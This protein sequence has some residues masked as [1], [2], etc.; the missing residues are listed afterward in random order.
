MKLTAATVHMYTVSSQP[1]LTW[2]V[3]SGGA[4]VSSLGSWKEG[5]RGACNVTTAWHQD[6]CMASGLLHGIRTA[7]WHQDYCMASRLL[8]GIRTT[9]WYQDYCMA[10]RLLYGIRTVAWHQDYCMASGLLRGIR[11]TAWHQDCF[12]A[13]G[14]LYGIWMLSGLLH[15]I[16]NTICMALSDCTNC[17]LLSNILL[18]TW[19]RACFAKSLAVVISITLTIV[20]Y[21]DLSHCGVDFRNEMCNALHTRNTSFITCST[22]KGILLTC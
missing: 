7:L 5:N 8:Y 19:A 6:Y 4:G 11:T 9:V 22:S 3:L 10:S 21:W 1:Q 18:M 20:C 16:R 13:S 14:L 2:I 12:M 17:I 15:G